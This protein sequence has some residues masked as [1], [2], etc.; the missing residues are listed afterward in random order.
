MAGAI[1][2]TCGTRPLVLRA[3]FSHLA[4]PVGGLYD[5]VVTGCWSIEASQGDVSKME[6]PG[7]GGTNLDIPPKEVLGVVTPPEEAVI[8]YP[9]VHSMILLHEVRGADRGA[10]E[11]LQFVSG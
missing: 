10:P 6:I 3:A 9:G 7:R 11:H 4:F 5:G 8:P 1:W 2:G